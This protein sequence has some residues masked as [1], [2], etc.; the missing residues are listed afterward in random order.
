MGALES[1][2]LSFCRLKVCSGHPVEY[3]SLFPSQ[4]DAGEEDAGL[5]EDGL[6]DDGLEEVVRFESPELYTV[7]RSVE[8]FGIDVELPAEL[9][10]A[11]YPLEEVFEPCA[12]GAT[13][14][15]HRIFALL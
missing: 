5:E 12:P 1:Y 4:S 2:E 3:L 11:I 7:E 10:H 14:A 6:E 13:E 8:Y 9:V 15:A